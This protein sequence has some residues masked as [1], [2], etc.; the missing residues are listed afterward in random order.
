MG[1]GSSSTHGRVFSRTEYRQLQPDF[2]YRL[3][4]QLGL[5]QAERSA[6]GHLDSTLSFLSPTTVLNVYPNSPVL[7]AQGSLRVAGHEDDL[8]SSLEE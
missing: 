2:S 8:L 1:L 6:S 4:F 5:V 7:K 3:K